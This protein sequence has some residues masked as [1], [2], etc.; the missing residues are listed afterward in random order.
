MS[1]SGKKQTRKGSVEPIASPRLQAGDRQGKRTAIILAAVVIVLI[2]AI[3]GVI[4]YPTYVAPFRR[5]V[6]TVDNINI[7]MDYFLKRIKLT[8]SDPIAMLTQLTNDQIVKLGAPKYVISVSS[9]NVDQ[10]MRSIFQGQSG[11]ASAPFSEPEYK[12]WYRQLLNESGLS[13]AEYRDIITIE[14]YRSRLQQYLADRMPTVA[15]QAHLH[16]ITLET[17][18]DAEK[19]RTR[20]EAGEKFADLARELSLDTTTGEKGGEVGWFPKGVIPI[21]QID[22]EAF[23]LNTGNMSEP[24]PIISEE[25]QPEGGTAST[26]IGYHLIMVSE[27]AIRE[28]DD[29]SLQ[30]LR[31]KVVDSWLSTQRQNYNIQWYGLN[32]GFDSETYAWINWQLQKE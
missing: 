14:L 4:G 29:N 12:E 6:I 28:L 8:G 22:F 20:W 3:V 9:D 26:I 2:L 13:D 32:D 19:A 25:E 17:L 31:G 21:S 11:N 18:K 24:L 27:R 15:E 23:N 16:I 30:V 5:T 7:R 10:A 1:Q